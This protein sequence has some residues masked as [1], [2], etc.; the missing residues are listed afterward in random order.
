MSPP[1]GGLVGVSW[2]EEEGVVGVRK[3]MLLILKFDEADSTCYGF[4]IKNLFQ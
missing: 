4:E 2:H 3:R 1:Q